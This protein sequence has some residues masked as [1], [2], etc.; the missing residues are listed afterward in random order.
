[1]AEV[2]DKLAKIA[3]AFAKSYSAMLDG[4]L[5]QAAGRGLHHL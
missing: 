2:L 4:V 1:V 5:A 3:A